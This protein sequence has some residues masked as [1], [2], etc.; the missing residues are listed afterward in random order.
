MPETFD[1][2]P[3]HE[4]APKIIRDALFTSGLRAYDVDGLPTFRPTHAFAYPLWYEGATS[5]IVDVSD[6]WE[7]KVEALY[8]HESQF[9][10]REGST[11]T[12]DTGDSARAY[13]EAQG[14]RYGF[15]IGRTYGEAYRSIYLP[16]G[17]D[18]PF[19]LLPNVV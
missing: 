19:T 8:A 16:V 1:R 13:L 3:D 2:H 6:A 18:D 9:T 10:L 4:N 7:K 5:F 15:M 17:L 14:R 11:P 12:I